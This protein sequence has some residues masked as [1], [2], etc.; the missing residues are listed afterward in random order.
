MQCRYFAL[1]HIVTTFIDG[2]CLQDHESLKR[3]LGKED[4]RELP[5]EEELWE[6]PEPPK[7]EM[8]LERGTE[9]L[10]TALAS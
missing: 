9:S 7:P 8:N 10:Y 1:L 5:S 6:V 2:L 3:F 4:I